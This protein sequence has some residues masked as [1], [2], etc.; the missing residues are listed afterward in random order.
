MNLKCAV[1]GVCFFIVCAFVITSCPQRTEEQKRIAPGTGQDLPQHKKLYLCPM[2]PQVTSDKPGDCPICGMRLVEQKAIP[3][4]KGESDTSASPQK[5]I[6]LCPMHPQITSDKPGDCPICGMRLVEQKKTAP[7]K[8]KPAAK[9]TMYRSTMNPNEISDKPGKDSMGMDLVPFEVEEKPAETPPRLSPIIITPEQRTRLGLTFGSVEM[10][11]ITREVHTSARIVPDET[12]L[13]TVTTKIEGYVEKLFVNVTGQAVKRGQPLLTVYSPELVSSQQ[14]YLTAISIAK[15][16]SQSSDASIA[17]GGKKLI[18]SARRR[19]KLWDISAQQIDRLEKT[20][21]VE[22]YLTLYAPGSGYVIDKKILPGQK[23]TPGEPLLVVADLSVVWGEADIYQSDLPYIKVGMP[24]TLT[25][26]YWPG[27]IFQGKVSF[28]YPYL[29]PQTRTLKARLVIN[30]PE[31]LLR[32]D[33]YGDAHLSYNLGQRLAVP[34]SAVMRTGMQN[35][36]F[37][38]GDNDV[39][40]P[41]AVTLGVQSNEYFEVLSGLNRGDR[42]VTSANFLIDSESS[43]KAAL[44]AITGGV[45]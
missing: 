1:S 41:V 34:D 14:E 16:L 33:M 29:D 38:A 5:K 37:V 42:V 17:E 27:K 40:T 4:T 28:L 12:R 25:L 39:I 45:Q 13:F 6:Y 22:K 10:R 44:Q 24:I 21:E 3:S 35:Y 11:D 43:L 30:N 15:N 20:G 26:A 19:L 9:K 8:D 7:E 36:V 2:H 18:E 23:I 32:G 31:L